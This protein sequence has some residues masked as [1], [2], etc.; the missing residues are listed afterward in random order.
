MV[1]SVL[2]KA[3]VSVVP[4]RKVGHPIRQLQIYRATRAVEAG[5]WSD[6]PSL[7]ERRRWRQQEEMHF[8]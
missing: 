3:L 8:G 7:I 5:R 6:E 2:V 4:E 1:L